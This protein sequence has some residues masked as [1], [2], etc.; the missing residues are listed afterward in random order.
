LIDRQHLESREN[1][2]PGLTLEEL[3]SFTL[4]IKP[5]TMQAT[6]SRDRVFGLLPLLRDEDRE[7]IVVDYS[8]ATTPASV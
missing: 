1:D 4:Y 5:G 8:D 2:H 3:L 6:D 7:A